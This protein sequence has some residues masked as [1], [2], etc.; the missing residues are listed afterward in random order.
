[1]KS[2]ESLVATLLVRE[3][4]WTYPSFKVQ[5]NDDDQQLCGSEQQEMWESW[6]IDVLAYRAKTNDVLLV[7]CKSFLNSDGVHFP[8]RQPKRYKLFINNRLLDAVKSAVRRELVERE[9][10]PTEPNVILGLA[11]SKVASDKDRQRLQEKFHEE[12]WRL[13][14][15]CWIRQRVRELADQDYEDD[16]A[17]LVAKLMTS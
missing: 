9:L 6:E 5:L 12:G 8:F 10:C 4:Y 1:M 2:F 16:L 13:F 3:G 11:T 15:D 14:D 7:E 17:V